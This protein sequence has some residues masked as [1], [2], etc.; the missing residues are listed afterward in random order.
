MS[1]TS[2]KP[3]WDQ[4]WVPSSWPVADGFVL[5]SPQLA[6]QMLDSSP[7]NRPLRCDDVQHYR[8]AMSN[9]TWEPLV[10]MIVFDEQ[11]RLQEGHHRLTAIAEGDRVVPIAVRQAPRERVAPLIDT[12][13]KR[14]VGDT[15]SS[16]FVDGR[17]WKNGKDLAS[18]SSAWVR[19]EAKHMY[20]SHVHV[21]YHKVVE[22]VTR[23]P[24]IAEVA[25]H[26]AS[27]TN[28]Q[29]RQ[30]PYLFVLAAALT[31]DRKKGLEFMEGVKDGVDLQSGDA[32]LALRDGWIR[33]KVKG[34][35]AYPLQ[36]NYAIRAWNAFYVGENLSLLR[37]SPKK[38]SPNVMRGLETPVWALP[39]K[40]KK[41]A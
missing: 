18:I 21:D 38:N 15:L 34:G 6:Q 24:A 35:A 36:I 33:T 3:W 20:S 19:Y 7:G 2:E 14:T 25:D 1:G 41:V 12:G 32:R 22:M 8:A 28:P 30:A 17:A 11:C 23:Y 4:S 40:L 31:V 39:V 26:K 10:D 29:M 37:W 16:G 13:R 9:G 27:Y 5:C